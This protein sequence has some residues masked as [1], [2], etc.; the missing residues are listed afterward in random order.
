MIIKPVIIHPM[1][2]LGN[3]I[4][5]PET[6]IRNFIKYAPHDFEM[7]FVGVTCD[8]KNRPMGKW[9]I[10]TAYKKNIRFL[11]IL[12]VRD[13][14]V[15][16]KIPLSLKFTLALF[17]YKKQVSSNNKILI[18]H[19]IEPSLPLAN[20]PGKKVGF[21]HNNTMDMLHS[22]HTE[23]KWRYFPRLYFQ[24][25]KKLISRMDK[26]FVVIEDMVQFYQRRY[27]FMAN[28]FSFL[29]TWVD[30]ETFYPYKN[31]VKARH[32]STFFK[33]QRFPADAKL[34]LFVGRLEGQKD[35]L[36]LIDTFYYINRHIPETR[37]L[38]VG[39]GALRKK[40]E[41]RIEQYGLKERVVFLGILPQDKVAN[42]MKI[43]EIFLL[44]SES[45]GMPRSVLEA[46]G[47]GL[48]V[49]CTDVGEVRRVVRDEFSGLICSK[50]NPKAIGDAVL[51]IL[52]DSKFTVENCLSSI[53][54]YTARRVLNKV[55]NFY[56]D[57]GTKQ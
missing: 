49:V 47:C 28:R 4:G 12:Y 2:L 11:P 36:L 51:K 35:P 14:N 21:I 25:E 29:P 7:E 30:E 32:K 10:I 26:V 53:Q 37:L 33:S 22:A 5:G 20:V 19:R 34:I 39:K 43:S 40:M 56:C 1:D 15:R 50:R 6:F 31:G 23:V 24:M 57:L 13:E 46:L 16:T 48:P 17:R 3:K 54:D 45:E 41:N 52:K 44:T 9:Q 8:K 27:P 42:L 55:Y 38:I 18:Y